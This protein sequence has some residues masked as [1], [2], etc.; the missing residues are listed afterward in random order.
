MVSNKNI[1][2]TYGF[3]YLVKKKIQRNLNA[4][5]LYSYF[6]NIFIFKEDF[7]NSHYTWFVSLNKSKLNTKDL[8]YS[9]I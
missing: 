9:V 7:L 6:N 5:L 3:L 8:Q 1:K 4:A 2:Q